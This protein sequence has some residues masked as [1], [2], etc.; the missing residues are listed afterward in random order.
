MQVLL[1]ES[2]VKLVAHSEHTPEVLL[3]PVFEQLSGQGTMHIMVPFIMVRLNPGEHSEQTCGELH[4]SQLDTLQVK[5]EP[6]LRDRL[7]MH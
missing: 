5:Q 2:R 7:P 3:H 1:A 6:L 4:K